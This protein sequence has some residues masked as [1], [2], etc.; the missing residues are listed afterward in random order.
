[1]PEF[2]NLGNVKHSDAGPAQKRL[3]LNPAVVEFVP[4]L[5]GT[6]G[7]PSVVYGARSGLWVRAGPLVYLFARVD[8]T[9]ISGGSGDL[10]IAGA[11]GI[12]GPYGGQSFTFSGRV[13]GVGFPGSR[14][15]FYAFVVGETIG[16]GT[17]G[18]GVS[19][20][21]IQVSN[22]GASGSIIVNGTYL[23]GDPL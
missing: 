11:A 14:T 22:A 9:A 18:E 15:G 13:A 2:T 12:P 7:N 23:T 17:Y 5:I 3:D 16:L 8:W 21:T 6:G 20:A 1:M 19:Q 10:R 4:T